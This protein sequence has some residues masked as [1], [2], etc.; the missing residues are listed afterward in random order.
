MC[1]EHAHR[2]VDRRPGAQRGLEVVRPPLV[3][4]QLRRQCHRAGHVARE[5]RGAGPVGLGEGVRCPAVEVEGTDG[6]G[7][8]LQRDRQRAARAFLGT[9]PGECRPPRVG[10]DVVDGHGDALA[11]AGQAGTVVDGVLHL[12]H[13]LREL[14]RGGAEH[15]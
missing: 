2:L 13:V 3:L 14:V 4:G 10:A 11:Q 7:T 6:P 12:V 8:D 5:L 9:P 1:H 15:G